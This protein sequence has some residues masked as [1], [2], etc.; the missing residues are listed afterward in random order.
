ML[1]HYIRNRKKLAAMKRNYLAPYLEKAA[2]RYHADGFCFRYAQRLVGFALPFARWLGTGHVPP[3][4]ITLE[5]VAKFLRWY[6]PTSEKS[7]RKRDLSRTAARNVVRQIQA[8][9]PPVVTR[10]PSRVEAD[11]YGDHLRRNRGVSEGTV[12]NH[13][14]NL[15]RFLTFCF[16]QR[17]VDPSIFTAR[18][19]HAYVDAL[20]HGRS[21]CVR[22]CTCTALRGY[23]RFLQMQGVAIG[24]LIAVVPTVRTPRAAVSPRWL[25][26][27]DTEQL[28]RSIDRSKATGKRRYAVILCM[29]HLGIRVG[30]VA[31]LSLDDI[32]WREG[33]VQVANHK[34]DRP[35]RL[36]LPQ[37][38]GKALADYLVKARPVSQQR[39]IFLSH[40][41][42]RGIPATTASLKGVMRY[43]WRCA[44]LNEK[45][46]GTHVLRHS[47]ATRMRQKG[48]SMKSIAD[49]LGHKSVQTTKVYAQV[50]L[51]GL[52]AVAQPWPEVRS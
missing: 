4:Q 33:T 29:I 49:V 46:S 35:Y 22:R 6:A 20:P 45:F 21:N 10:S 14:R 40:R 44:G 41:A 11:R 16:Q 50:N 15:E 19:V 37:R 7:P 32:D 24:S 38:L 17:P 30:D 43:A 3:D 2:E 42:P 8:A 27:A 12:E 9:H 47:A 26:S 48:V 25:T 51:P 18:R 36:P 34:P 31:R 13:Q 1:E 39:E 52:R 5:H 23:F 28:L